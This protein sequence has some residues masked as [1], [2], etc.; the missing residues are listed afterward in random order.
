[1]KIAGHK[2]PSVF[3]RY[4]I[5]AEDD[6]KQATTALNEHLIVKQKELDKE[7]EKKNVVTMDENEKAEISKPLKIMELARGIEPPTCGLQN[8]CS[9]D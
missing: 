2:T 7:Q 9:A 3:R 8:R 1:M 4:N 6:L 5:T